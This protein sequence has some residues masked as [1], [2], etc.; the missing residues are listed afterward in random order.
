M[1][2]TSPG[3][4]AKIQELMGQKSPE[5]RLVMSCSMHDFSKQLVIDSILKE[6]PRLSAA[7]VRKELFLR[8]YGNEFDAAHQ[9]K[10]LKQIV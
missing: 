9:K 3:M 7:F 4:L 1:D 6:K 5:E 10:I 8:Y 2:D